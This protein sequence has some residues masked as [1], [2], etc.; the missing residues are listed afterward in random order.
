LREA[1]IDASQVPH[2]ADVLGLVAR[3]SGDCDPGVERSFIET[4]RLV[5]L[6]LDEEDVPEERCDPPRP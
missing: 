1:D 6:S 5:E 2:V 4:L 3:V